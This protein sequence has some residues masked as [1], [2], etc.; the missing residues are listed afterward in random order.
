MLVRVG[1][2]LLSCFASLSILLK[3]YY[4]DALKRNVNYYNSLQSID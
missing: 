4:T 1:H 3:T 2:T